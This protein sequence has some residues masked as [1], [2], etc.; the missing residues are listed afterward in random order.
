MPSFSNEKA[1]DFH[2]FIYTFESITDKQSLSQYEKFI[3]LQ[4]TLS[5]SPRVLVDSFDLNER[6]YD[7]AKSLLERSFGSTVSRKNC[8]IKRLAEI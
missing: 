4:K 7:S 1:E 5:K 8:A 3:L 2:K 6:T